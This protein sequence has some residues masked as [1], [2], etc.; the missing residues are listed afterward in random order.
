MDL[1]RKLHTHMSQHKKPRF[2]L[3]FCFVLQQRYGHNPL[4]LYTTIRACLHAEMSLVQRAE[5]VKTLA[6]GH[7]T[8]GQNVQVQF[9][10]SKI[11]PFCP[12]KSQNIFKD[13]CP[14]II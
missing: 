6:E 14:I 7:L 13:N 3:C 9:T 11:V 4:S 12:K 2:N 1:S 8:L 5:Q 10:N